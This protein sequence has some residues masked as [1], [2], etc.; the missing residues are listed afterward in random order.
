MAVL[1]WPLPVV[2]RAEVTKKLILNAPL[3]TAL[4][5]TR[6]SEKVGFNHILARMGV[7]VVG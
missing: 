1:T 3:A 5:P 6:T 2:M 7:N 4:R